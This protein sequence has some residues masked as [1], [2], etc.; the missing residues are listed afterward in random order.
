VVRLFLSCALK[1]LMNCRLF[2]ANGKISGPCCVHA[3]ESPGS[4]Y[5][6]KALKI[7]A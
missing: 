2:V 7:L 5:P 1:L 4:G 3:L 6:P